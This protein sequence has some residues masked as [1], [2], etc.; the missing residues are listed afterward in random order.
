VF[1][2]QSPYVDTPILSFKGEILYI[3]IFSLLHETW[4]TPDFHTWKFKN[5]KVSDWLI[6]WLSAWLVDWMIG[7][8]VE[9]WTDGEI[10]PYIHVKHSKGSKARCSDTKIWNY[11]YKIYNIKILWVWISHTAIKYYSEWKHHDVL[12]IQLTLH[13]IRQ[14]SIFYSK[15]SLALE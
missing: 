4:I 9:G 2:A 7:G 1:T 6:D 12:I 3:Y 13:S 15:A 10:L 14:Y 8:W 5:L 11:K